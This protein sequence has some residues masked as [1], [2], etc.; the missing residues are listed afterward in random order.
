MQGFSLKEN[1]KN[2]KPKREL[3]TAAGLFAGNRDGVPKKCAFCKKTNHEM[4]DCRSACN[5]DLNERMA[6]LKKCGG[7]FRCLRP[8]HM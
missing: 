3:P 4:K 5:L 6:R 1:T 7:C 2:V 8:G